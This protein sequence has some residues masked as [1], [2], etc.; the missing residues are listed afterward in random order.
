MITL[1]VI[2]NLTSRQIMKLSN[3]VWNSPMVRAE[4]ARLAADAELNSEV[5]VHSVKTHWNTVAEVLERAL[6]MR[7]VLTD[8]CDMVQFNKTGGARLRRFMLTDDE[9]QILGQLHQLL[10]VSSY[11]FWCSTRSN[12]IFTAISFH[13]E[14]D[15]EQH[16]STCPRG[17]SL[18][19]HPHR[20]R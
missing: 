12:I 7:E 4:L 5:L 1:P 18:H 20:T 9:W 8:L 15:F 19:R 6:E 16:T 2:L 10:D 17:H 3:K 11:L 13:H 14:A